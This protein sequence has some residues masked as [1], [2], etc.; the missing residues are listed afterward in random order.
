MARQNK[1]MRREVILHAVKTFYTMTTED[2]GNVLMDL[3][4]E[5]VKL[6]NKNLE[7]IKENLK[8][9]GERNQLRLELQREREDRAENEAM[10]EKT[11]KEYQ[12]K[13]EKT[14]KKSKRK[15]GK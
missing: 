4:M 12:E 2:L 3:A 9:C 13:L 15:G 6:E 7:L 1:S 8:G 10:Y 11:I 5:N 14:N